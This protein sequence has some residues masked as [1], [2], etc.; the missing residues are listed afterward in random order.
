M[1]SNNSNIFVDEEDVEKLPPMVKFLAQVRKSGMDH[2]FPQVAHDKVILN[3]NASC[4]EDNL[5]IFVYF[6][7]PLGFSL[8]LF[9]S[10]VRKCVHTSRCLYLC[11]GYH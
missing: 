2:I 4:I 6:F 5:L 8:H 3:R 11:N 1:L 7:L 10:K 9:C